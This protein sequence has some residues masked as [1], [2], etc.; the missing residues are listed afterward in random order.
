MRFIKQLRKPVVIVIGLALTLSMIGCTAKQYRRVD[1]SGFL[2]DYSQLHEKTQNEALYVYVNPKADCKKYHKVMID[3]VT[4]WGTAEDSPLASLD[5]KDQ[6]M[7]VTQGWGM[8]YD[9]MKK[10]NFKIVDKAGLDVIHVRA[11]ITEATKA[12]VILADVVAVAPYA[13]EAATLWGMGTGKWPF[14]GE[15]AGEIEITDSQ[16]G[17]RLFAAVDKVVGTMGSN[18]DPMA[19]WDDVRKG[20]NLWRDRLGKRME[21][22]QATGSF[23]MP[24]DDRGFIQKS[25]EYMSP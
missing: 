3:P 4:L 15:L 8:L 11:A 16:T 20:F 22:C 21:S 13:W 12:N 7:L 23:E 24:K 18:V 10:G 25:Y 19:R 6:K 5:E 9:G 2:G 14:L 17:E 1:Q